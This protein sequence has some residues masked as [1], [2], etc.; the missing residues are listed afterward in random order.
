MKLDHPLAGQLEE[1]AVNGQPWV[2]FRADATE[3]LDACKGPTV[4]WIDHHPYAQKQITETYRRSQLLGTML[5]RS[6]CSPELHQLIYTA[7]AGSYLAFALCDACDIAS[8]M[9]PA[10]LIQFSIAT[11]FDGFLEALN[12]WAASMEY[13]RSFEAQVALRRV[14]REFMPQKHPGAKF[15][16]LAAQNAFPDLEDF[17]VRFETERSRFRE[18]TRKSRERG[19]LRPSPQFK[20]GIKLGWV[21]FCFWAKT[22]GEILA[23]LDPRSMDGVSD[24]LRSG[25]DISKLRFGRSHHGK[26]SEKLSSAMKEPMS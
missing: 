17:S 9:G 1:W 11:R 7:A 5:A 3:F 22:A 21:P 8:R 19:T 24:I 16:M 13:D 18:A 6:S 25:S 14:V 12:D 10:W 15:W 23:V 20:N 4:A 2:T 26:L